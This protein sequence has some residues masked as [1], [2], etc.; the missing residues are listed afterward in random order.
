MAYVAGKEVVMERAQLR[1]PEMKGALVR[2]RGWIP[3]MIV[4]GGGPVLSA[5]VDEEVS[6]DRYRRRG[7]SVRMRTW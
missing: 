3:R 2:R 4:A 7:K 1:R 6:W 5:W